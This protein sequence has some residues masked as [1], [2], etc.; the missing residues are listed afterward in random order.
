MC[1]FLY[2]GEY[3]DSTYSIDFDKLRKN[4]YRGV[5]FDIDNTL[6]PHGAPADERAVA[7]FSHLRELGFSCIL[8]SNNKEPRVKSFAE[9]VGALY[10]FKAGKPKKL[11]YLRAMEK[12]NTNKNDTSFVGDQIF[13]DVCGANLAGIRT[14]LVK[15]IHPKEEIQIVLKR[16]LEFLV[17]L[18]YR[19]HR[20]LFGPKYESS[21]KKSKR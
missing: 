13:T 12:M 15:P 9:Q 21:A 8:L 18:G 3:L 11:G 17:L 2:P 1:A 6:V 4:G 19:L 14:I 20:K 16:K 10:I 5:I 7:L